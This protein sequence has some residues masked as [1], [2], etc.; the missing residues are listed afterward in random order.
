MGAIEL[1]KEA[2]PQSESFMA[3]INSST[4]KFGVIFVSNAT[5]AGQNVGN[6]DGDAGSCWSFLMCLLI[7]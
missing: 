6:I 3:Y 5:Q 7:P 2:V 4:A 1:I